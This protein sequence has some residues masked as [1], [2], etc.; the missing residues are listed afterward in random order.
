MGIA[1]V[2]WPV[3][4]HPADRL[5]YVLNPYWVGVG[6]QSPIIDGEPRKLRRS[7]WSEQRRDELLLSHVRKSTTMNK[8][9][10][11]KRPFALGHIHV[12][13]Q[14]DT[15]RPGVFNVPN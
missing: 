6:K 11:R 5:F 1:F 7:K 9:G 3:I 10:D 4:F 8:N 14:T 13:L 15:V 12:E 2:F